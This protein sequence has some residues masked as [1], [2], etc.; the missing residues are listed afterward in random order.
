MKERRTK[1]YYYKGNINI[2]RLPIIVLILIFIYNIAKYLK[3]EGFDIPI[4]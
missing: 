2:K 3:T 4:I 1:G